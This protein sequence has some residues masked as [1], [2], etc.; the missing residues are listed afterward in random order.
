MLYDIGLFCIILAVIIGIIAI[1]FRLQKKRALP[2][3]AVLMIASAGLITA[4][5]LT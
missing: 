2:L 5:Y 1:I 3:I 4:G